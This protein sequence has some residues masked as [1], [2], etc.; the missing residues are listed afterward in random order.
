MNKSE[1]LEKANSMNKNTLMETLGIEYT[2]IGSNYAKAKMPVTSRVHQPAGLLHGGANAA[3][4]ES[5][6][7]LGS[8][9]L[10]NDPNLTVVGIEVNANHIKSIKSGFVYAHGELIHAGKSTHVWEIKIR[11]GAENLLSV[12]RLTNMIIRKSK[13]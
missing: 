7:S 2:D 3:L 13:A 6:G 1:I 4:A 11:D 12:C 9:V 5:L 8:H 10:L